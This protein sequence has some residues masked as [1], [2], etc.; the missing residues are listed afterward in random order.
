MVCSQH[1]SWKLCSLPIRRV[2]SIEAESLIHVFLTTADA[3]AFS[4]MAS[5]MAILDPKPYKLPKQH[6][7]IHKSGDELKGDPQCLDLEMLSTGSANVRH[8]SASTATA[9]RTGP[10]PDAPS[11]KQGS[12]RTH[13]P[14]GGC[15]RHPR[16]H[17]GPPSEFGNSSSSPEQVKSQSQGQSYLSNII[18]RYENF[19]RWS[20][21][22]RMDSRAAKATRLGDLPQRSSLQ[23]REPTQAG[24][25]HSRRSTGSSRARVRTTSPSASKCSSNIN[26]QHGGPDRPRQRGFLLRLG[27]CRR[28]RG[29]LNQSASELEAEKGIY[30]VLGTASDRR[31]PYIGIFEL[32]SGSSKFTTRAPA[33]NMN[34][35]EPQDLLH[36]HDLRDPEQKQH[37]RQALKKFKPWLTVLGLSCRPYS[38]FNHNINYSWREDEW[39]ELQKEAQPLLDFAMDVIN[40]QMDQNRYFLQEYPEKLELWSTAEI[41]TLMCMA[42]VWQVTLDTGAFGACIDDKP[43]KKPM[44]FVGNIP[45]LEKL[46]N[47]R[48]SRRT[49]TVHTYPR[50]YD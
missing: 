19:G 36:G 16:H 12:N 27:H 24:Q 29:S 11:A 41:D 43:I 18:D 21:T 50:L 42:G 10:T 37:V 3:M 17:R 5:R 15:M 35:L 9:T 4:N 25:D 38:I 48:L 33:F 28:L 34:T 1:L 46:M 22:M 2:S 14:S 23:A 6:G 26:S 45:G 40:E 39:L 20:E 31:F 13:P 7:Q 8:T 49:S 32:F 30:E 44:T 47:Q